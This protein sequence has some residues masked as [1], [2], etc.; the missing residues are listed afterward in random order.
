M[1]STLESMFSMEMLMTCTKSS[2]GSQRKSV[3]M[4]YKLLLKLPVQSLAL[5]EQ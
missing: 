3:L 1:V 2:Y 5:T 4:F